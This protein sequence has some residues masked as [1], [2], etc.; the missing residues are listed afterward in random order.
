MLVASE[1]T[2]SLICYTVLHKRN[3]EHWK[4]TFLA[5]IATYGH[6][7]NKLQ[8]CEKYMMTRDIRDKF[9]QL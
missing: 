6:T 5:K 7:C 4:T 1:K 2:C 8:S 3:I 9:L